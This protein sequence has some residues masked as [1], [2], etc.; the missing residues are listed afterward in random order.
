MNS[1]ERV[2]ITFE[3]QEPDRVPLF[4]AWI[5]TEIVNALG[6]DPYIARERLNLDCMPLGSHPNNTRAYGDGIDEWGRVFKNGHYLTGMIRSEEDL[7]RYTATLAHAKDW[8]PSAKIQEIKRKYS[9]EYILYFGWHDCSL[10]LTYLRMGIENFF[11]SLYEDP[12]LV[13]AVIERSTEWTIALVDQANQNEVDF[14]ILGDDAAENSRPLISPNL[15]RELILPE[16]K[17]IVKA[18][19]VP[20]IW[21]SDGHIT[22]LLPMI[23][24]AGFMGVHS[25][26]P[27]ANID[28]TDIKNR[29]GNKLILAGNLDTTEIL[30]QPDL[31][32]VRED[33]E[34]CIREGAPGGGYLFSSSNSLFEG[35]N[36]KAILEAYNH[37]KKMG[38]YPI[39][40]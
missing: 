15:F 5:E 18:S 40:F 21:H 27:K 16:Y 34:R 23:I 28:L 7:E 33:V 29:Y 2:L 37:A 6:G 36:V 10:G 9:E 13:K 24:E 30:C 35:H 17:K 32:L 39:S 31:D 3:R 20:I 22:P 11:R 19:G 4:E 14:L 1:R 26:E 38:T 12:E 8:F 25:L